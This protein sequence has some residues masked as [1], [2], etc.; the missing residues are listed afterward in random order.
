M[1]EERLFLAIGAADPEL[2]ARS[3]R[4]RSVRPVKWGL[5]AAA[6]LAILCAALPA[7]LRLLPGLSDDAV[8]EPPFTQVLA[9]T[10]GDVGTLHLAQIHYG[11]EESDPENFIL[12]V[13][14]DIYAGSWLD[15]NYVILPL[16]PTPEGL[17]ECSLTIS[18]QESISLTDAAEAACQALTGTF[19]V[20]LA[21]EEAPQR[22][23][24]SAY[25]GTESG[26]EWDAA[27]TRVTLV[28]DQDG[29]V[30]TLTARF[31]TEASEG[32]GA[33]F[34][35]MA[36][37]FRPV[38]AKTAVPQWMT[39]LQ[40]T[41]DRLLPAV[42]SNRWSADTRSLL[43]GDAQ[44]SCYETDVSNF[45]SIA[46]VDISTDDD[47]HPTAAVASVRHRMGSE[48]PYRYVTIELSCRDGQWS[49][50]WIGLE[51]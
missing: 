16:L 3:D 7:L 6:C 19:S 46:G 28:D 26:A 35:D 32:H 47:Q 37:T 36:A 48:E 30:F 8:V 29:G 24:L 49:A 14:E 27:N 50:Y 20:V 33:Q 38:P 23:S 39:S 40:S 12:Y 17:P 51:Q 9:L 1:R 21:P 43:T 31:F 10:G 15:G 41:V 13:N 34:A 2:L 45:V 11:A 25:N 4:R 22:I 18:H 5:A 42:F 44:V